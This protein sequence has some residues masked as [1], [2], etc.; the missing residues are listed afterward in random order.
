MISLGS[1]LERRREIFRLAA[2]HG[3]RNPRLFGSVVR[4]E[5]REDSDLDILVQLDTD[6]SLIDHVALVQDLEDLLNCR[7]DVVNERALDRTIRDR[8]LAE[9]VPL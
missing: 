9:A 7:V 6:R 1:I 8:V 2:G 4:G 3:A 5:A